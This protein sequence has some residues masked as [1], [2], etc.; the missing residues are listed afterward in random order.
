M[1]PLCLFS[2][3]GAYGQVFFALNLDNGE[4][5]AVKQVPLIKNEQSATNNEKVNIIILLY[6]N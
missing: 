6:F 1:F 4:L 3:Y 5:M 2:R